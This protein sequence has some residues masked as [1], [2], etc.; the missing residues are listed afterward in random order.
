M[1]LAS[2]PARLGQQRSLRRIRQVLSWALT[3]RL[4]VM[5]GGFWGLAAV[6]LIGRVV[7]TA[8]T[9]NLFVLHGPLRVPHGWDDTVKCSFDELAGFAVELVIAIFQDV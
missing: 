5:L 8:A 6:S 7:D 2:C 1:A 3:I 4:Q 9:S